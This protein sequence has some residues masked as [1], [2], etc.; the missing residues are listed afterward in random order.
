MPKQSINLIKGDRV[1]DADYRDA[2][3]VNLY[4][5]IRQIRGS[6]GYLINQPGIVEF[7]VTQGVDRGGFYSERFGKHLRVTGNRLLDIQTDG[8]AI[9]LGEIT[10]SE[11]CSF[12]QSFNNFAIVA[13]GK[14]WY[15]NPNDGLRQITDP[16]LG[17]P[18]DVCWIAGYFFFTDGESLF[19][20]TLQDE[21]V[22]EPLDFATAE[23]SPDP[24]IAV[25]KT[26]ENQVI[27]FGRYSTEWFV[28]VGSTN[29]AFA[30]ISGKAVKCGIVSTQAQAE[31]KG[32]YF[33]IG[34]FR[35]ESPTMYI[36]YG[37]APKKFATREI[38]KILAEYTEEDLQSASLEARSED[39]Y[40]FI[41]VNLP[42]H[43]LL[44]NHTAAQGIG[45]EMAWSILKTSV[46]GNDG[47]IGINGIF[48]QRISKWI[49]GDRF[50]PRVGRLDNTIST[51]YGNKVECIFYSPL[52]TMD[53]MSINEI[54]I[55]TI[56]GF[57]PFESTVSISLTYDGEAY[58]K[59]WFDLYGQKN[60]RGYRFIS[61]RIGYVR[62]YVG[63][64]FRAVTPSRL[65]F[66]ALEV[67]YG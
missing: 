57:T 52:I 56:S 16:N 6:A 13:D 26:Q 54:E 19:H 63:F 59:E 1:S 55:K 45:L 60:Q 41:H 4:T 29:F 53:S 51:L 47:W 50:N 58:S 49:Y 22:I 37:G 5:V 44:Y 10:G 31:L 67:D 14:L 35:E 27:V 17:L 2:L 7:G 64:K 9:D 66:G 39:G 38:D 36:I 46:K 24:T 3:P 15:Y 65:A 48:D 32:A 21:E 61:R 25:K 23:F 12:A 40:D 8:A 62:D 34:G 18:T 11:Q 20:T 43:T 28:N 30:P 42:R 33:T